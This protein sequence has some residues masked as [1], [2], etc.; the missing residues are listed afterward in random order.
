MLVIYS[1]VLLLGIIIGALG[2]RF[3]SINGRFQNRERLLLKQRQEQLDH[4]YS[5]L[6]SHFSRNITVL[7]K[8]TSDYRL[9]HQQAL[10][11]MSQRFPDRLLYQ[12]DLGGEAIMEQRNSLNKAEPP[13]D[14]SSTA[15]DL[16]CTK[17]QSRD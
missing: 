14:Y 10:S 6:A 15:A 4:S 8:L 11:R 17:Q 12:S 13:C 3:G 9:L 1:L 2:V 5:E 7:E 16:L